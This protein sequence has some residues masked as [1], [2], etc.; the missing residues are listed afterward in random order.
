MA[1]GVEERWVIATDTG[2]T[3]V[4]AVVWN[5]QGKAYI[6]KAPSTPEDPPCGI[7]AA[8]TAAARTAGLR[9]EEIL[10]HAA[11]FHNGTTVT[12]NAM[13]E[14]KGARTGLLVTAGF[15]DTLAIARVIG[16]TIGLDEEELYDFRHADP[17]TPIVPRRW[18][19]GI[20]ERVDS[21]G[22]ILVPVNPSQ[23]EQALDELAREGIE[24]LAISFLWSFRNPVNEQ[25]VAEIARRRYPHWF[26][27]ASSELVP[28][29]GEYERTN[30]TVVN[31]YLEPVF[32]RYAEGLSQRLREAGYSREPLIMQSV[33]GLAAAREIAHTPV[34]T[35]FSG[36]VGG[37]VASRRLGQ[38]IQEPNLITTDMGGTSFDVGL[39]LNG[40][41]LHVPV[42]VIDRQMVAIPTVEV[43]TIGAGGGSVVRVDEL[44]TLHVGPESMGAVPGPACY[45]RGGTT[46]TVTDADV[47]LG[48]ID[49][50]FFLGG[51]MAI[52]RS[53]AEEALRPLAERLGMEL[54]DLAA[55]VYAVVNARMADLIRR[56]TVERGYDPR[57]FAMVAFGGCG[58][59]HCTGYAPETGVR[60]VVVPPLATVFS[61]AGI[62]QSDFQHAAVRSFP[63][64]LRRLDGTL[65]E[66]HLEALNHHLGALVE[67]VRGQLERDGVAVEA[68]RIGLSAELRYRNQIHELLVRLPNRLPLSSAD[69]AATVEAFE[70]Q[71]ELRYGRGAS[72]ASAQIEWV[73]LRVEGSAPTPMP[74]A[75]AMLPPAD[76]G[77][78]SAQLGKKMVWHLGEGSYQSTP[79]YQAERLMPGHRLEGPAL[80]VSYGTTLPLHEGQ[81]LEVDPFGNYHVY[82][83]ANR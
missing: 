33:G 73:R 69:L 53:R 12:T 71:Y 24:V 38:L 49:P 16:R 54:P 18:V 15:E 25:Q 37:V 79:V 23:V 52:S 72:A 77:V 76:R 40:E 82:F 3:F 42:T 6:G 64:P 20:T 83:E 27:I 56:A 63:Y 1:R 22:E 57:E 55:G 46:P 39:I 9:A 60:K 13:L 65:A 51:T 80:I 30:T 58:P 36:P 14:R 2:G 7:L 45:G 5:P 41:P 68:G 35:L 59:T 8:V 11:Y 44:G 47:V 29:L 21:R 34:V 4:D 78:E 74:V 62:G 66:E 48:Y 26:V 17:P 43:V 31:A 67:Q 61:A 10:A 19:K 32:S 75:T 28:V 70:R 50:D 81:R